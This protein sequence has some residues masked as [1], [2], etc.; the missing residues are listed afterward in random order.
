MKLYYGSTTILQEP[1]FGEGNPTNDYGLGFYLTDNE[2][3][4]KLWACKNENGGYVI[5]Y[6]LD[7]KGLKILRIDDDSEESILK[8]ITLL[9]KNR[10]DYGDRIKYQQTIDWL[11]K[12][13]DTP[14]N[15]IDLVIGYRADDSYF[16]YSRGFVDGEI[17]L[18]T[19]SNALRIGK[20]GIQ[21]V[22]ISK[23]A[24]KSIKYVSHY[25]VEHNENYEDFRK[26]TLNEY[27][28][29]RGNEDIVNNTFIRDL[30]KKYGN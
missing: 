14:I 15:D 19:L 7:I 26:M 22:L 9:L 16:S 29:L 27:H 28:E 24:F 3:L 17:S 2:Y 8:W 6:D 21:Y 20:L 11:V 4:A 12:H 5:T 23:K 10:F 18:E 13:F 30:I 25:K 1:I